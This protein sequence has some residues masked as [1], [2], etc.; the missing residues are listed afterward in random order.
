MGVS[1][2]DARVLDGKLRVSCLTYNVNDHDTR[3]ISVIHTD[4]E[5]CCSSDL[6]VMV[7][8]SSPVL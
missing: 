6:K 3:M 7:K 5:G 4:H 1:N 2:N 8:Y